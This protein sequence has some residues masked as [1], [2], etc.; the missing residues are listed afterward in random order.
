MQRVFTK[1]VGRF[2]KGEVR[3][4]TKQV[5]EGIARSAKMKLDDFTRIAVMV[6]QAEPKKQ[7]TPAT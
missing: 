3:D 5:W 2:K 6:E 7:A 4:Y 1:D